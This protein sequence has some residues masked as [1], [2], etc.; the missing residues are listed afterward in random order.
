[1]DHNISPF[2]LKPKPTI[3]CSPQNIRRTS[4]ILPLG[5]NQLCILKNKNK[6]KIKIFLKM[7]LGLITNFLTWPL[8]DPMM[9]HL[10]KTPSNKKL[11]DIES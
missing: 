3:D 2:L 10:I 5:Q 4:N 1:M 6:N 9:Q 7:T 11:N 8:H